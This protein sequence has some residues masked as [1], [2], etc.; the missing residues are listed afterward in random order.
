MAPRAL[1]PRR[2]S[3]REIALMAFNEMG[4]LLVR[5]PRRRNAAE[6]RQ[7]GS[8]GAG[9]DGIGNGGGREAASATVVAVVAI[10]ATAATVAATV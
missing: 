6:V 3:M 4:D 5:S 7:R 9:G 2:K 10:V 1:F 8:G